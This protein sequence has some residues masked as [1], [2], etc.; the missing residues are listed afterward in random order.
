[1]RLPLDRFWH[2]RSVLRWVRGPVLR[3]SAWVHE[4]IPTGSS[5]PSAI[6][7]TRSSATV[8][9]PGSVGVGASQLAEPPPTAWEIWHKA[10]AM[11][12]G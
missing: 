4:H 8:T 9:A 2:P 6:H 11:C 3:S 5:E 10:A 7:A 12:S 1:M